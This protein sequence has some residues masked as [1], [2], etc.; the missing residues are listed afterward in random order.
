[1][2]KDTTIC[3][4]GHRIIES[5]CLEEVT[6]RLYSAVCNLILKG[7]DS[8][9][10]GGAVGFDTLAA[11]CIISFKKRFPHIKLI[12]ALPCRDQ[13][14][15]WT[16]ISD[17]TKYKTI[18]GEAD[19]VYYSANLYTESCMLERNRFM[20]DNSSICIAYMK[21]KRGGTA[22]TYNYAKTAELRIIN[23][24]DNTDSEQLSF[25]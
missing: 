17:I 23:L 2:N 4:T 24:Y 11:E 7:F 1:M 21:N 8:F 10:C 12:L 14:L 13:T 16:C 19:E 15:K 25:I 9:I 6:A 18:L 20:V 22:Y 3:F 5:S